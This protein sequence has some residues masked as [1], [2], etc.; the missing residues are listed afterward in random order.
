MKEVF[1]SMA[2]DHQ[3]IYTYKDLE[4]LPEGVLRAELI[5]GQIF[6]Y[7]THPKRIHQ[8]VQTYLT[9]TIYNHIAKKGGS[10]QVYDANF[11]VA[12][13]EPGNTFVLPDICVVCD[14]SKL[15]EYCCTG[16]PDWIIEIVSPSSIHMDYIRKLNKYDECGVREYWIVNPE[17]KKVT[18]W[19]FEKDEMQEYSFS[20]QV[21]AGIFEDFCIDFSQINI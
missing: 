4:D 14:L 7:R 6:Y 15:D 9:V 5:D 12:L 19:N 8:F 16:A 21:P 3:R 1:G 11:C 2:L 17:K 13:D 18:V 20:D 10:C